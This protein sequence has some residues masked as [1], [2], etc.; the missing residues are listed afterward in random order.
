MLWPIGCRGASEDRI[1]CIVYVAVIY[2]NDFLCCTN[3]YAFIILVLWTHIQGCVGN[4]TYL[5]ECLPTVCVP[6]CGHIVKN[7]KCMLSCNI[8]CPWGEVM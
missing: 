7:I 1:L 8:F 2:I 5:I 6:V 3:C 4:M